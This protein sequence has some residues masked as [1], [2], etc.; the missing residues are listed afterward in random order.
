MRYNETMN[1]NEYLKVNDRYYVN[2][3]LAVDESEQFLNKLKT[4]QAE[5]N[6]QI[7]QE[8]HNLGTDV[9]SSMGGLSGTGV[10]QQRYQ[11]KPVDAMV[12]N[13]KATTQAKALTD[14]LTNLL[15]QKQ[16]EYKQAYRDAYKKA[17][18]KT[19]GDGSDGE[20]ETK[21][22]ESDYEITG[23]T[24]GVAGGYTVANFNPDTGTVTGYTGVPYGEEYQTNYTYKIGEESKGAIKEIIDRGEDSGA[25]PALTPD[26]PV[27]KH[28][29][30]IVTNGGTR[31]T[32]TAENPRQAEAY[33]Y[34][35]SDLSALS[36]GGTGR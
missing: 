5:G 6:A 3:Q 17:N 23:V 12:A 19:T 35:V 4:A 28:K 13:L 14:T 22:I 8:T 27:K 7:A 33:F 31:R 36:G 9:P 2:P 1:E 15:G 20:V 30:E 24:P 10:W 11:A 26:G 34:G 18:T 21:T 25:T 16:Q 32:I 29:Y